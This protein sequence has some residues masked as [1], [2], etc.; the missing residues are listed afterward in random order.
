M[1]GQVP[2]YGVPTGLAYDPDRDKF[3]VTREGETGAFTS[4]S[5]PAPNR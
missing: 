2:S 5:A 1:A 4:E 3:I